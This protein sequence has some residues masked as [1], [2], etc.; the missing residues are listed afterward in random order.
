LEERPQSIVKQRF[1]GASRDPNFTRKMAFFFRAHGFGRGSD[2]NQVFRSG[3]AGSAQYIKIVERFRSR[4]Y[5]SHCQFASH[6]HKVKQ[7]VTQVVD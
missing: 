2:I 5:K 3:M 7:E 1:Q 6:I 4:V